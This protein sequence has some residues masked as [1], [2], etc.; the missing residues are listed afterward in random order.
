MISLP[1]PNTH[2][3]LDTS[4]ENIYI[5]P[6]VRSRIL[7]FPKPFSPNTGCQACNFAIRGSPAAPGI[8]L[9][10]TLFP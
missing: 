5:T 2:D 8:S 7:L 10:T 1:P 3:Y 6:A 9:F 4:K